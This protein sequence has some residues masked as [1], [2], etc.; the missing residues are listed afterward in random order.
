[1]SPEEDRPLYARPWSSIDKYTLSDGEV[2]RESDHGNTDETFHCTTYLGNLL[3]TGD[4]VL[5]YDLIT[6]IMPGYTK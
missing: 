1:M 4:A 6:S 2:S 5:R 3:Q